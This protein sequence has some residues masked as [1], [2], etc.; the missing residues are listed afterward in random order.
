M[1]W[2]SISQTTYHI[3]YRDLSIPEKASWEKP[4]QRKNLKLL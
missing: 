2:M 4:F 1:K 3:Q